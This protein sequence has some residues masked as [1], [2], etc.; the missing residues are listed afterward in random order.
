MWM[1]AAPDSEF[2]QTEKLL[3]K[4]C[5]KLEVK[6]FRRI[7]VRQWFAADLNKPFARMVDE[8]RNDFCHAGQ[9]LRHPDRQ[10]EGCCLCRGL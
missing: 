10:D 4:V 1:L 8:Y 6:E 9:T 3:G 7:G 5:R 2:G